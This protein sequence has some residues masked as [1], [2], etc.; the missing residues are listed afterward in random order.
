MKLS[1]L[2]FIHLLF[3]MV[4]CADPENDQSDNR[5]F[6]NA[7]SEILQQANH[8]GKLLTKK[9]YSIGDSLHQ[10]DL[11]NFKYFGG[12][13]KGRALYY[14][15]HLDTIY[16]EKSIKGRD[17][18]LCFFDNQIARVKYEL[19]VDITKDLMYKYGSFKIKPLD[20]ISRVIVKSGDVLV[21]GNDQISLNDQIKNYE[22][23]WNNPDKQIVYT[24]F[25]N[26]DSKKSF[27]YEERIPDYK[28]SMIYLTRY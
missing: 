15:N 20:S 22:L 4:S 18:L 2:I 25:E 11:S 16:H 13:Y 6:Q 27:I 9:S 3:F 12:F 17:L 8:S 5:G 21:R 7:A 23:I 10:T 24:H 19:D 28:S 1:C 14:H 26:Y